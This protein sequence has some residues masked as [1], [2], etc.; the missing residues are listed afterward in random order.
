MKNAYI[1]IAHSNYNQLYKLLRQLDYI[2]NDFFIHI[3]RDVVLP[4]F[5][6]PDVKLLNSKIYIVNRNK[7]M[8]GGIGLIKAML[9]GL[10]CAK[11][12]G[13]Y[14]YYHV[15]SGVDIPLKTNSYINDFLE[16]NKYNN[17]SNGKFKTNYV[18][19]DRVSN[20]RDIAYGIHYNLFVSLWRNNNFF[21]RG[22]SRRIDNI[23][24]YIQNMFHVNR[25]KDFYSI[26]QIAKGSSW[27]SITDELA[28]YILE[29]E[30]WIA[31][32]FSKYTFAA[33]EIAIQT[34]V[35]NSCFFYSL[36]NCSN[37][38]NQ[39]MRFID[40]KRGRPYVFRSDDFDELI[41]SKFL[42]ARKVDEK[43]DEVIID[44]L[45]AYLKEMEV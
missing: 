39:N 22:I 28:K 30:Q 1:I 13:T 41:Q 16:T 25:L 4:S 43:I 34:L 3:N 18:Y 37:C 19:I 10:K 45:Y 6:E 29:H 31:D 36:Y 38:E 20:A 5:D 8:W 17:N 14:D 24:Y 27:W 9:D 32:N 7:M 12:V 21:V 26:E 23:G 42:F 2:G 11:S 15:L 44:K 35:K 33:D 40:W